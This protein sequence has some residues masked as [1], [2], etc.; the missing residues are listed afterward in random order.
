ML[1]CTS[2]MFSDFV[3]LHVYMFASISIFAVFYVRRFA[4]I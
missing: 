1:L 3:S 2:D 4:I